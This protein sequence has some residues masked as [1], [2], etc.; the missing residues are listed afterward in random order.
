MMSPDKQR[1]TDEIGKHSWVVGVRVNVFLVVGVQRFFEFQNIIYTM[2]S[3]KIT[4]FEREKKQD[5]YNIP[6]LSTTPSGSAL[7]AAIS[8]HYNNI[9]NLCLGTSLT[10]LIEFEFE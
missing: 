4:K 2:Y 9:I 8:T 7:I 3:V 10:T 6:V 1:R 5:G